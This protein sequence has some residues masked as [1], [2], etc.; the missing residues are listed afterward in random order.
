[1]SNE[2]I[3]KITRDG[4]IYR[5][6]IEIDKLNNYLKDLKKSLTSNYYNM[7]SIGIEEA[8]SYS[9]YATIFTGST[10][11]L[12]LDIFCKELIGNIPSYEYYESI[13]FNPEF[14]V[15]NS[16]R[17]RMGMDFDYRYI[18]PDTQEKLPTFLIKK[19]KETN[20]IFERSSETLF[21]KQD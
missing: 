16:L 10:I 5:Y 6:Y 3:Y 20:K 14:K 2:I 9:A 21:I 12:P 17:I 11:K 19:L 8:S 13:Y 1:M 18:I 15:Y 7:Q 4:G